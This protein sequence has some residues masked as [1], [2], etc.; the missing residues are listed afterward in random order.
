[1][2]IHIIAKYYEMYASDVCQF[3]LCSIDTF[4]FKKSCLYSTE[5]YLV[6]IKTF[7]KYAF[8]YRCNYYIHLEFFSYML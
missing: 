8:F 1:M 5:N 2:D 6:G 7:K 3:F 4:L